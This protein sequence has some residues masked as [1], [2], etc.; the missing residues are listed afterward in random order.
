MP[1]NRRAFTRGALSACD[2]IVPVVG[3]VRTWDRLDRT[4]SEWALIALGA[5]MVVSAALLLWEGRH[6]TFFNDEW[7]IILHRRGHSLAILLRAENGHLILVPL[8]IYKTLL[9]VFGASY[10]PFRVTAVAFGL[11][12][13]GLLFVLVRRRVGDVPALAAAVLL[14]F[15]GVAWEQM[16]WALGMTYSCSLAAGLG[17]LLALERGDRRGDLIASGLLAVSLASLSIGVAFAVAATVEVCFTARASRWRRLWISLVPLAL[18]GLWT[19]QY[20]H[21]QLMSS[22]IASTPFYIAETAS[23]AMSSLT[24]LFRMVGTAPGAVTGFPPFNIEYGKPLAVL[25]A[26]LILVRLGRA[27]RPSVRLWTLLGLTLALWISF[28]LV[29][30]PGRSPGASRYQ[31]PDVLL[32][33]LLAAEVSVGAVLTVR[34]RLLIAGLV[35][36][37]L[38]ANIANL[39]DGANFLSQQSEINR[40][41]LAAL[42]LGKGTVGPAFNPEGPDSYPPALGHYLKV[43]A[44]AYFAFRAKF[45]SPADSLSELARSSEIARE[46]ADIVMVRAGQLLLAPASRQPPGEVILQ[47]EGTQGSVLRHGPCLALLPGTSTAAVVLTVPRQGLLLEPTAGAASTIKMR[48]FGDAFSANLSAIPSG[49]DATMSPRPDASTTPWRA[50]IT[51]AGKPLTVCARR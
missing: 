45:G 43:E 50:T 4:R 40:A 38:I 31:Y 13:A 35:A 32:V 7:D 23:A 21:S 12:C 34:A 11:L 28:A 36:F 49:S 39:R 6:M 33:L 20:G 48:R 19:L 24:G 46:A 22:N 18:Y 15:L 30:G 10:T 5:A 51:I 47:A 1:A 14:L 26:I 17:M 9:A 37:S 27:A 44:G 41:E 8:L 3:P 29:A 25:G 16:L 42:E 2:C